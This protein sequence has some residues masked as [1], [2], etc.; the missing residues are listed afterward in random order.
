MRIL[1]HFGFSGGK[2]STALALWACYESGLPLEDIRITMCDTDNENDATYAQAKLLND[3]VHPVEIIRGERGFW[4]L[5]RWKKRFPSTKARFCTQFLKMIPTQTWINARRN[6]GCDVILYSGVRAAESPD[7]AKLPE[8]E[9]DGYYAAKVVR[10]LLRWSIDQVWA[11]HEKYSFPRNPLYEMGCH[12]VGCFP[13]INSRKAEI[14]VIA[15]YFPER[16][17]RLRQEE[18]SF[19]TINGISTFFPRNKV[20]FVQRSKEIQTKSRGKMLVATIDDV[21]RWA[22]TERGGKQNIFDF[23]HEENFRDDD[24]GLACSSSLGH[25]E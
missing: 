9:W 4:D 21:V 14:R 11:I 13:C 16:I 6:E 12:R 10:P 5:A 2:D 19:N 23:S 3:T 20:P 22:H 17:E 18:Q 15:K 7:R 8:S 24:R 1:H 25:C